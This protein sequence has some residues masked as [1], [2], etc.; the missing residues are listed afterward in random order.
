MLNRLLNQIIFTFKKLPKED[1]VD[2]LTEIIG[3][4]GPYQAILYTVIGITI[5]MHCWQMMSNKFFT[6]KTEYWCSRPENLRHLDV[7]IW[8]N[9]S[10]P[11]LENGE[12]D[13]CAV[14]DVDYTNLKS[15]PDQ[16]S[17]PT[18]PCTSWEYHNDHFQ[19]SI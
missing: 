19:V 15:R 17:V 11:M 5:S 8:L 18:V 16:K 6:Y 2:H 3:L 13:K 10:S 7:Q 14:F 9:L 4:F 1:K 12:F